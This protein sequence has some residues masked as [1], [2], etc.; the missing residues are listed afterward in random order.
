MIPV[1]YMLKWYRAVTHGVAVDDS[2]YGG[3]Y[4]GGFCRES[5]KL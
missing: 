1:G 5:Q 2:F 3:V 4:N